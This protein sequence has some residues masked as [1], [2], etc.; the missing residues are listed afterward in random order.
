M[1]KCFYD[2]EFVELN[3]FYI[4]CSSAFLNKK[5]LKKKLNKK[6]FGDEVRET[7][8]FTAFAYGHA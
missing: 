2:V 1:L 7:L 4:A 5:F 6:H 3:L 8:F